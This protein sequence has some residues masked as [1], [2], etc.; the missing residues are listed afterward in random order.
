[1]LSNISIQICSH[2]RLQDAATLIELVQSVTAMF[3]LMLLPICSHLLLAVTDPQTDSKSPMCSCACC[4]N[5]PRLNYPRERDCEFEVSVLSC[6]KTPQAV[7]NK[8]LMLALSSIPHDVSGAQHCS[9]HPC[10]QSA[11]RAC[12]YLVTGCK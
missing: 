9:L 7:K 8:K 4:Q 11:T 5:V 1:M 3:T 10:Q 2:G 12:T 6:L